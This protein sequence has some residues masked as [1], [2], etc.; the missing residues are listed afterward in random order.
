MIDD[1]KTLLDIEGDKQDKKIQLYINIACNSIKSY[2]NKPQLTLDELKANYSYAIIEL[3]C[4]AYRS[5][6]TKNIKQKTQGARSETYA[7]VN[8][9]FLITDDIAQLLPGPYVKMR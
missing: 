4:K 3:V 5:K 8:S 7:D 6:E 1:I 9:G 2:L